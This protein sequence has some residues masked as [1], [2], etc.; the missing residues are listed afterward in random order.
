[1]GTTCLTGAR[2]PQRDDV[3]QIPPDHAKFWAK[4]RP[5]ALHRH[6]VHRTA[7]TVL[8]NDGVNLHICDAGSQAKTAIDQWISLCSETPT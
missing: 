2:F 4:N 5:G 8:K 7:L 3:G 6:G 1:M